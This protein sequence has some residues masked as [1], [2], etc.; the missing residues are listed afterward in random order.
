MGSTY[1]NGI[2]S[3]FITCQPSK[4]LLQPRLIWHGEKK[5]SLSSRRNTTLEMNYNSNLS[6]TLI[7]C[8]H[9]A[10]VITILLCIISALSPADYSQNTEKR[11]QGKCNMRYISS[12]EQ[13]AI[14]RKTSGESSQPLHFGHFFSICG[15]EMDNSQANVLGCNRPR[16]IL[17]WILVT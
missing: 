14:P 5:S 1:K 9:S 3:F 13:Q 7:H 11:F 12:R 16:T 6:H 17:L 8:S 2:L 4:M 10:N 15:A